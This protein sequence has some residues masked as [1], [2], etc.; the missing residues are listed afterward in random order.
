MNLLVLW[1]RKANRMTWQNVSGKEDCF[2]VGSRKAPVEVT[3]RQTPENDEAAMPRGDATSPAW[4]SG[5]QGGPEVR[6]GCCSWQQR[7]MKRLVGGEQEITWG[8]RQNLTTHGFVNESEYVF[9]LYFITPSTLASLSRIFP[10]LYLKKKNLRGS[11]TTS[12]KE[13]A[14]VHLK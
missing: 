9:Y 2:Q 12:T 7:R 4:G 10:S 5:K 8:C 13:H 11:S 1:D 14:S 6:G 3:F